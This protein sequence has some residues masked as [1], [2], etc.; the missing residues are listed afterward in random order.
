MCKIVFVSVPKISPDTPP[1]GPAVLK[2]YLLKYKIESLF[3]DWNKELF[4]K[5]GNTS[6][7]WQFGT[8]DGNKLQDQEFDRIWDEHFDW[9]YSYFAVHIPNK[10]EFI[11]LSLFS[12][13]SA[14]AAEKL[15]LFFRKYFPDKKIVIGGAGSNTVTER[16]LEKNIVDHSIPGD[17]EEALIKL[18][19]GEEHPGI[20]SYYIDRKLPMDDIPVGNFDDLDLSKYKGGIYIRTSKGCVLNCTFCDVKSLWNKYQQQS[21]EKTI[22]DLRIIRD[23]YPTIK[24]VKF[25]DSLLNGSM[26]TFRALLAL[27]ANEKFPMRFETKI[28]IRPAHQM[29]ESDYKLMKDAGFHLVLPGV[30]SGSE[31]VRRHMGKMFTNDDLRFF[32]DNMQENGLKA[33]FLF[34]IGYI[35]ETEEDFQET[36]D[37]I[38][39]IHTKYADVVPTIAMGEQLFVLPGSPLYDRREDFDVFDHTYW[40]MNGNTKSVRENRNNRLLSHAAEMNINAVCRK[41]SEGSTVLKY[42]KKSTD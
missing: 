18:L 11:G 32:M 22:E 8:V 33:L 39:L 4:I 23:K 38:T 37:L 10:V 29:P 20:D 40:E 25:A 7:Y 24:D 5:A 12:F 13:E 14:Y 41:A 21:P 15:S 26:S 9:I 30:E 1:A 27:M 6:K 16:F 36:L 42:E 34:I 3:L 28:I 35:T 2:A 19:N 31:R 17:G